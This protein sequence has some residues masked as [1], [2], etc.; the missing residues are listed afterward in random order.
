LYSEKI[1]IELPAELDDNSV[2]TDQNSVLI[3]NHTNERIDMRNL[4]RPLTFTERFNNNQTN[5]IGICEFALVFIVQIFLIFQKF[6]FVNSRT[7]HF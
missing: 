2:Q 6:G 1:E 4:E 3:R 5:A 7:V